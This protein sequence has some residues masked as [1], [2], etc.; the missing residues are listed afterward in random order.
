[1]PALKTASHRQLFAGKVNQVGEFVRIPVDL[2]P[3][4]CAA[5]IEGVFHRDRESITKGILLSMILAPDKA[6]VMDHS[7]RENRDF[8]KVDG[9]V[10]HLCAR[11]AFRQGEITDVFISAVLGG[12]LKT[13]VQ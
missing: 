8:A 11:S 9:V 1:M 6:D 12:V 7:L 4:L 2:V 5:A 13:D 10:M 3:V